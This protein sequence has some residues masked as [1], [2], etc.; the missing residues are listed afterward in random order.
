V[1]SV[2]ALVAVVATAAGAAL[3]VHRG[4]RSMLVVVAPAAVAALGGAHALFRLLHGDDGVWSG[5]L[6]ST[7][8]IAAGLAISAAAAR[9]VGRPFRLVLDAIGPAALLA[10]GIGRLGCFLGGCCYGAPSD[11]PWAVV[12]SELGPPARHPLQLYSAAGDLA[13]V[14]GMPPRAAPPGTAARRACVGFG[15]L[16]AALECLRDPGTTD[17]LPGGLVTL[18]Q[19][20]ALLL[21]ATALL[22][23]HTSLRGREPSTMP[24]P[25]RSSGKWPTRRR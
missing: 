7:G 13:L 3:A 23:G 20:A 5:G 14:A 4:G 22:V 19:A 16:R 24:P 8:G 9:L 15:L 11:L 10:L 25:R 21:A 12:F 1:L 6:A 17:L 2:H 18:P